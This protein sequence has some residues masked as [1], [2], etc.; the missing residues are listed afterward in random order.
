MSYDRKKL[1][2]HLR[3]ILQNTTDDPDAFDH[4]TTHSILGGAGSR[5]EITAEDGRPFVGQTPE[6]GPPTLYILEEGVRAQH[7]FVNECL[8]D[9]DFATQI[10]AEALMKHLQKLLREL[11][12]KTRDE[13]DLK[14]IVKKDVLKAL[15]AEVRPWCV[16]VPIKNLGLASR[17]KIGNVT[18]VRQEEGVVAN[19]KAVMDIQGPDDSARNVSDKAQL[20]KVVGEI[21]GQ[22]TAWAIAEIEAH[23]GRVKEVA[24]EHIETA[25]NVIRAF[26]HVFRSYS[27][28]CAFGLP[29]ELNDGMTG[30]VAECAKRISIQQDRRGFFARF[31]L[32]D[33]VLRRLREEFYFDHLVRIAGEKWANLNSLERAIRV[34]FHW[35]G[36][37]VI[38]L[39]TAESFTHCAITLER[40]LIVDGEDTTAEKFA[41]RLAYLLADEVDYRKYLHKAAKRLYE[42][43]SKIVHQGFESVE[44]HQLEEIEGMAIRALVKTAS[45]L[46]ELDDHNALRNLLHQ[47]KME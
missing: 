3:V 41:D 16:R 11:H 46:D 18:F 27:L 19:T 5:I 39:T 21:S 43:R 14:E 17:L 26:T 13:L 38:A 47:R 45:L 8:K 33:T 35:L 22:G 44:L 10:G 42:V 32:N 6:E 15:R 7:E 30:F 20:L 12:P 34:A 9:R 29:Y 23:E 40:I 31:E 25:I 4:E 1:E 28:R 37:S 36:R 2:T 24:R